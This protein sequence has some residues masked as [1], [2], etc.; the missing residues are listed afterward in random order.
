MLCARAE[1]FCGSK[2]FTNPN[3][4]S[5]RERQDTTA[6]SIER[7]IPE[8]IRNKTLA[9]LLTMM[10]MQADQVTLPQ[11]VRHLPQ[12]VRQLEEIP[13]HSVQ[14]PDDGGRES[15][16]LPIEQS[17]PEPMPQPILPMQ[18]QNNSAGLSS[19]FST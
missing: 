1:V 17:M 18:S 2:E 19:L 8:I 9:R 13:V 7:F 11:L 15:P 3:N 14:S 10:Q 5:L 6:T 4:S 16:H 12:L